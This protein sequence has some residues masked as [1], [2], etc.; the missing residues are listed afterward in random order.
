MEAPTTKTKTHNQ[1]RSLLREIWLSDALFRQQVIFDA[2]QF[3]CLAYF[4]QKL[5]RIN[6]CTSPHSSVRG[7]F[8]H[9]RFYL[10]TFGTA[11]YVEPCV[12]HEYV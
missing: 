10:P 3:L 5:I 12:C 6:V 2:T 7:P 8:F 4:D 1:R 11:L 9:S